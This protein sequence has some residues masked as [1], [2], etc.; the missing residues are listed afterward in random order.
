MYKAQGTSDERFSSIV[1]HRIPQ[2]K[3]ATSIRNDLH[4]PSAWKPNNMTGN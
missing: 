1:T 4:H 2:R 3:S